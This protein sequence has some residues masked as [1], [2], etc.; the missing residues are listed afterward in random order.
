MLQTLL[1]RTGLRANG[2]YDSVRSNAEVRRDLSWGYRACMLAL[3]PLGLLLALPASL[4]F[5]L[6]GRAGTL[7]V[8]ARKPRA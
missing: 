3:L 2:M 7:I 4:V 6:A 1:N 5:R 8:V